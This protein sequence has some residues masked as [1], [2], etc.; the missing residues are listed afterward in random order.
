MPLNYR[1]GRTTRLSGAARPRLI[2]P[3]SEGELFYAVVVVVQPSLTSQRFVK[4]YSAAVN[5]IS[6]PTH[7]TSKLLSI[8]MGMGQLE[9]NAHTY[10]QMLQTAGILVVLLINFTTGTFPESVGKY[11]HPF[12]S[13][14]AACIRVVKYVTNINRWWWW[15]WWWGVVRDFELVRLWWSAP[16][17]L[18][19]ICGLGVNDAFTLTS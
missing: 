2:S 8:Q 7:K 3:F 18:V 15:R 6:K 17:W 14:F 11:H 4:H 12:R 10:T 13:L 5:C 1:P 9:G 19:S 16:M